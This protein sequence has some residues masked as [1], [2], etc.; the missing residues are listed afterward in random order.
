[1]R[2]VDTQIGIV[3]D[4]LDAAGLSESTWVVLTGDHGWSLGEHGSWAKVT[5]FETTARVPLI[6]APPRGAAGWRTNAT[7]GPLEGF[8]EHLDIFPTLLDVLGVGAGVVPAGQLGGASLA[9]LLRAGGGGGANFSAAFTQVM[10]GVE[11]GRQ[12]NNHPGEGGGGGGG[13][14]GSPP[15]AMGVSIRVPGWRLTQWV[16]F[17]YGNSSGAP[18]APIWADLR[19]EELYDHRADDAGQ[20]ADGNQNYDLSELVD[21]AGDPQFKA[22]KQQL[23][24][25][26][27]A[28]WT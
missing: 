18:A 25:R 6:I 15:C 27:Q 23:A 14:G 20:G 24:A 8:V 26:L 7:V 16:G 3:L 9:P 12:C 19:G 28:E 5:L 21:V 13:G 11:P 2:W 10:R 17:D 4:A 22:V 1:V